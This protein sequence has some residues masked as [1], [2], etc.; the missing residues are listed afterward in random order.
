MDDLG[1]TNRP[2]VAER[3]ERLGTQ[4]SSKSFKYDGTQTQMILKNNGLQPLSRKPA[5]NM[6]INI[7][8]LRIFERKSFSVF[9]E[10]SL[11]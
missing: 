1:A 11:R 10:A 2:C 5:L 3:K 8:L 6:S 7:C 4:G 9:L